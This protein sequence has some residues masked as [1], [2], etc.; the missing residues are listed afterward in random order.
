MSAAP[1]LALACLAACTALLFVP[2]LAA[3]DPNSLYQGP[4]RDRAPTSSTSR[5]PTR[6]SSRT[7]ATGTRRR[8]SSPGS[9]AY[10]GGEFLYQ[11]W[12]YDDSGALGNP[13]TNDPR[14]DGNSFS[15]SAGT[16]L[17]PTDAAI[18]GNNA[19]DLVELRVEPLVTST[20]FRLTLNTIKNSSVV[21]ATIAIGGTPGNAARLALQRQRALAGAVLPDRARHD[22]PPA[23]VVADLRDAVTGPAGRHGAHREP[24]HD[25]SPDHGDRAALELEPG[26]RRRAPRGRRRPL[27]RDARAS[28]ACRRGNPTATQ[29][30]GAQLLG[31]AP[32]LF[33]L[34]F[35]DECQQEDPVPP[36]TV[37]AGCEPMPNV[38]SPNALSDPS[39]WRENAQA[40]VLGSGTLLATPD[41]SP[42]FAN[43]DF[44]KLAEPG[45]RRDRRARRPAR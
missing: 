1:R 24:R 29:P 5:S 12:L 45:Q 37:P 2:P 26:H 28:T 9:T 11:D 16:Y 40:D 33:N 27:E 44:N 15:R 17:Y 10:R 41:I 31:S 19:A 14:T 25:A 8:S 30:G 39:W 32:A 38:Q 34:A 36:G 23:Q 43:V 18:Y 20:A 13:V 7:P 3:A 35:R 42:F 21:G 22:A 6:P 4:A